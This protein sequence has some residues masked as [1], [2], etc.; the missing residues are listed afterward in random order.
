MDGN[1]LPAGWIRV[2]SK[3]RPNKYYF[4][5]VATK[6]SLWKIEDVKKENQKIKLRAT[7]NRSPKKTAK[8]AIQEATSGISGSSKAIKRNV[9]K[10]RATKQERNSLGDEKRGSEGRTLPKKIPKIQKHEDSIIKNIASKVANAQKKPLKKN[11]AAQRMKDLKSKLREDVPLP[12]NPK[13]ETSLPQEKL[14]ALKCAMLEAKPPK[15]TEQAKPKPPAEEIPAPKCDSPNEVEMMDVSEEPADYE[16]M[17]WEEIPEEK[18]LQ[19]ISEIRRINSVDDV[20][21]EPPTKRHFSLMDAD[22]YVVVDTNVLLSN[23]DFVEEIRGKMFKGESED[24]SPLPVN[25][26]TTSP[27]SDIGK[28]TIYLPYIVL[29]ELDRLK[30]R[31]EKVAKLARRSITFIETCFNQKDAFFVGQSATESVK[32]HLIPISSGDDEIL[33]CCLQIKEITKKVLLLSNDKNL[34]N[35]AFVNRITSLSRDMM[36]FADF[37]VKNEITF[38]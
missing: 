31:E 14:E 4:H 26:K 17:D 19:E 11:L 32:K 12:G 21:S 5:H 8:T 2:E 23:I 6:M 3:S 7:K 13:L 33:N 35:K 10:P 25:F 22:F 28:A 1:E 24:F 29:D 34:R 18:I 9:D 38:E 20:L 37:N 15:P 16:P 36:N 30:T 27:I